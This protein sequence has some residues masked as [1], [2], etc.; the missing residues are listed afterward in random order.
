MQKLNNNLHISMK[1]VILNLQTLNNL[2]HN[3]DTYD[4]FQNGVKTF[5][6]ESDCIYLKVGT[7]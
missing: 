6:W 7:K 3:L 5:P 4:S 2:F 1:Q